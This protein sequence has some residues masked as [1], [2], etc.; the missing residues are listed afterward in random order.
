MDI[1]PLGSVAQSNPAFVDK[2]LTA[3]ESSL[4]TVKPAVAPV[5]PV[6]AVQQPA[7]APSMEQVTQALKSINEALREQ[8]QNLEFS[9]DS[10]SDRTIVK[11]VDLTTQEVIRQMPSKEAL[12]IAK[13]LDKAL[14]LLIRQKA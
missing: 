2:G 8:S 11:V 4:V 9:V 6:A 13:A 12:E 10:D 3:A 5:E 14:G 1:R 7:P